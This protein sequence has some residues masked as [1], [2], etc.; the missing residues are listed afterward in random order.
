LSGLLTVQEAQQ[1]ILENFQPR[2]PEDCIFSHAHGRVLA[3]PIS[4]PQDSPLFTNSSMDGYAVRSIDCLEAAPHRP[5]L[6]E[7][8]EDI[9]AGKIPTRAI[10]QGQASRIMTG[11]P[12]PNGADAVIPVEDTATPSGLEGSLPSSITILKKASPGQYVRQR[13]MDFEIGQP[14]LPAGRRLNP[15]DIGM[16]ASLGLKRIPVYPRPRIALFSSGDELV[17]PGAPLGPGQIYDSNQFVLGGLLK[18]EGADVIQ[19]GTARDN[20]EE[21]NLLL[22]RALDA[23]VDLIVTSAGVSVGAYDYVRRV[24]ETYGNLDFWRVN[25]RPGKPIAFGTFKGIPLIGLP[26]NPVSAY[27]GCMVF[28]LPVVRKLSGLPPFSHRPVKVILDEFVESDGRESYLR[29]VVYRKE[30]VLHAK[31]SGHQ[32]SGNLFSLVLAN[33]LLI[34]PSEVKSLPAGSE[35]DAW[36]ITGDIE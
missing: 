33:A 19:L 24:I 32:G 30:G 9:P 3:S 10:N 23:N 27:V 7:I 12:L 18:E 34:S 25:I 5:V 6:L 2:Q 16:V 1:R 21:V 17:L 13:G 29:A 26:G 35:A 14:I 28:V 15:Q 4:A 36:L 31:L 22:S 8:I 11:A 20:Q